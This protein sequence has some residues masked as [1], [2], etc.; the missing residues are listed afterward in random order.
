MSSND[1]VNLGKVNQTLTEAG[2]DGKFKVHTN[3]NNSGMFGRVNVSSGTEKVVIKNTIIDLSNNSLGNGRGAFI[4]K[5]IIDNINFDLIFENC[6]V[7]NSSFGNNFGGFIGHF[8]TKQPKD[9]AII[10]FKNC[11]AHINSFSKGSLNNGGFVARQCPYKI[12]I[13]NSYLYS[14]Q[15]KQI[16]GFVS[17]PLHYVYIY[18][19]V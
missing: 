14:N 17:Y 16:S 4:N 12:Y 13:Y 9:T 10:V 15:N 3:I 11:Y 19:Y 6:A 8:N 2:Y 7:I 5:K 1:T 18:N